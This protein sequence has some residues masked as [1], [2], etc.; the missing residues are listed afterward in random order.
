MIST[1]AAFAEAIG[2]STRRLRARIL[3]GGADVSGDIRRMTVHLG[4]CGGAVFAP[5]SVYS[6]YAEITTDGTGLSFEGQTLTIQIGAELAGGTYEYVTLGSFVAG[7]PSASVYETTFTAQGLIAA[8]FAGK[9]TPPSPQTLPNI[10]GALAEQTGTGIS[11]RNVVAQGTIEKDMS[12]LTCRQALAVVAGVLGGYATESAAG[13]V[14]LAKY[15][16]TSQH[17]VDG[18]RMTALPTFADTDTRITGVKVVVP[19]SADGGGAEYASGTD[20]LERTDPYMTA[21]L[22]SAYRANLVGLTYRPGM[23]QLALGDPRLEPWDT[24]AVTDMAG[25]V[26]TLP[27]MS[28]VHTFDGGLRTT[29]TAPA[30]GADTAILGRVGQA[31]REAL[32]AAQ[33]ARYAMTNWASVIGSLYGEMYDADDVAA[34]LLAEAN[35]GGNLIWNLAHPS[36]LALPNVL[37]DVTNGANSSYVSGGGAAGSPWL[38]LGTDVNVSALTNGF[39]IA[40][41]SGGAEPRFQFWYLWSGTTPP[42]APGTY[43]FSCDIESNCFKNFA[44]DTGADTSGLTY[45]LQFRYAD[46]SGGASVSRTVV[47]WSYAERAETKTARCA[48]AFTLTDEVLNGYTI[49]FGILPVESTYGISGNYTEDGSAFL[50]ITNIKLEKGSA[51]TAWCAASADYAIG[52]ISNT[53]IDALFS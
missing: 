24:L 20:E 5:G 32:D 26:F 1:S 36:L 38:H 13:S 49:R 48:C 12:G 4:S 23:A 17:A 30:P 31:V 45:S 50:R 43:V 29:V 41:A 6:S 10:I 11:L 47:S 28:I 44:A 51:A 42:L 25:R 39:Q 19:P 8:R 9:F 14:V 35:G 27:C 22:F 2:G 15:T 40:L 7:R 3:S 33:W 16:T 37:G 53:E 21:S 52:T 46:S 34:S 18:S